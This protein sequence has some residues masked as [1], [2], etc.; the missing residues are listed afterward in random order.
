MNISS[1]LNS[2][3]EEIRASLVFDD[4]TGDLNIRILQNILEFYKIFRL[5]SGNI[6][7][8]RLGF[9]WCRGTETEEIKICKIET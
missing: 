7:S 5:K 2:S 3:G 1:D 4:R 8:D 6:S 9:A